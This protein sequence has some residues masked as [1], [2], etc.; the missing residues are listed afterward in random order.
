MKRA[1]PTK[2]EINGLKKWL[3]FDDPERSCP[4]EKVLY[5]KK[6]E[7]RPSNK[8]TNYCAKFFPKIVPG[9]TSFGTVLFPC[10]CNYFR[11]EYV[12]RVAR[13]LIKKEK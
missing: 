4:F 7:C 13:E 8:S 11:L 6:E 9:Y 10:P 5:K 1:I 3:E 2:E 12:R